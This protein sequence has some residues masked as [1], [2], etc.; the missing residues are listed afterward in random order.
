MMHNF[1]NPGWTAFADVSQRLAAVD[2]NNKKGH[3]WLDDS[4]SSWPC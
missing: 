4:Y 1:L 3:T 2:N